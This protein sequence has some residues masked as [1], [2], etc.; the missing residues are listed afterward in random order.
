MY[1]YTPKHLWLYLGLCYHDIFDDRQSKWL[2]ILQPHIGDLVAS[3]L[4]VL[5]VGDG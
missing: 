3:D 4:A 1:V 2:I 5:L